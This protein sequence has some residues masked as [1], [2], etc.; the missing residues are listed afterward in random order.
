MT[1]SFFSNFLNSHQLPFCEAL[2]RKVGEGNF[3]FV[4]STKMDDDRVQMGWENMNETKPFVVRAYK[5]GDAL[6]E[7]NRLA[8]ESDVAIFGS[9][10]YPFQ[11]LRLT[12]NKLSFRYNERIFKTGIIRVLDPRIQ[13]TYR[14]IFTQYRK[15]ELYVLCA[16]AYTK[17]D[18]K[19]VGFPSAKCYKWG[20]FP[21][22]KHNLSY[23]LLAAKKSGS[24]CQ[25]V[26]ILW[27]GRLIGWKHPEV[28]ISIAKHLKKTGRDFSMTI[29]GDGPLRTKLEQKVV[30]NGLS[31]SV[32]MLGAQSHETVLEEME[33]TDIFLFTSDRN[34]GWGAV[35]NEAMNAGCA[36]VADRNIGSVP[37]LLKD[38]VN[39][40]IYNTGSLKQINEAI[41]RLIEDESFRTS[42]GATAWDTINNVWNI[43]NA[44][45]R[46]FELI[47]SLK[48]KQVPIISSGPC[49]KA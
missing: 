23:D 45:K 20:Y 19:W 29:I 18:L 4:A 2:I 16:S 36:V 41:D 30:S 44:T 9:A 39:G 15:K 31:E 22:M 28:A 35:L 25:C 3:R 7:A 21:E 37:F 24:K 48:N 38:G 49:S 32:K 42:L 33:K 17:N 14:A 1:I 40:L 34:E 46:F 10:S 12:E 6:A 43:E 8:K 13:K 11:T 27:A 26:S 47:D 5:G